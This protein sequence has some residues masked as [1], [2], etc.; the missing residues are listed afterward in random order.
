MVISDEKVEE[1]LTTIQKM[2]EQMTSVMN[3]NNELE[4]KNSDLHKEMI[5][6]LK[7]T[8]RHQQWIPA[9]DSSSSSSI[10]EGRTAHVR[11]ANIPKPERPTIEEVCDDFG[12]K[13]HLDK[14]NRFKRMCNLTEKSQVL[15]NWSHV[16]QR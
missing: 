9:D 3:K 12:W 7:S 2:M 8:A 4:Q 5:D 14:W 10:N 1:V 15:M 16:R 13:L 11:N 6:M